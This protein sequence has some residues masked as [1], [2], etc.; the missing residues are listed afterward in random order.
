VGGRDSAPGEGVERLSGNLSCL[1]WCVV[2]RDPATH[3]QPSCLIRLSKP[4]ERLGLFRDRDLG[5]ELNHIRLR[6]RDDLV[7]GASEV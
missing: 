5:L 2:K 1:E 7:S 6:R 3:S 4:S